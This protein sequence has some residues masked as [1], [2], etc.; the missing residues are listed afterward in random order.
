MDERRARA[1]RLAGTGAALVAGVLALAM[2]ALLGRVLLH[3][4][5]TGA[6][7]A[8][9]DRGLER[10]SVTFLSVSGIKAVMASI[11]GSSVGIGVNLQVGDLIQPAYDY[12]DFVW[13]IFL[14]AL[15]LLGLYKLLMETG[16][17]SL[18]FPILG[19]GLLL[20]CAGRLPPGERPGLSRWGR[21]VALLGV[22]VAYVVPLALLLSQ[23]VSERYLEPL[24]R[25]SAERIA[26]AGGVLDEAAESLGALRDEI[27]ILEPGRSFEAIRVES[28]NIAARASAAIWERLQAF[29]GY[30]LILVVELLILPFLSA[31]L[32]YKSLAV[33]ARQLDRA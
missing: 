32:V 16:I 25:S 33:A 10:N 26:E 5:A 17:L 18:G 7:E 31:F 20:L 22:A 19:I 30:V 4:A 15:T 12:V 14:Y 13:R 21:R 6:A 24:Q 2:P 29:L 28:R 23:L 11:E 27:S 3:E 1:V 8:T 9:L